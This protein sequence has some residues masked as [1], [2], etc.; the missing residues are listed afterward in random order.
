VA[1]PPRPTDPVTP[2]AAGTAT[3]TGTGTGTATADPG[4]G[5]GGATRF[6][7]GNRPPLTGIRAFVIISILIYHSNFETLPG[8]WASITVFFVLSGF[9]ITSMLV[10]EHDRT[11]R[12]SLRTF[13]ARR[14]VR[15]LPPL[16]ITVVLLAIYAA[17]VAVPDAPQRI[18]GDV[19]AAVF[20]YAD[21]R[22]ASGREPFFGYLGQAWSLSIEEQFYVVWSLLVVAALVLGRRWAAYLVATVGAALSAA[23]GFWLLLR[24]P[25]ASHA[26]VLRVYYGFGSRADALFVGCLLGL[27]ASSGHL[28]RLPASLRRLSPVTA[29]ASAA[30]LGWIAATVTFG[31]RQS[32]LVW[33][34]LTIVASVF[35]ITYFVACPQGLGSRFVGLAP[36][37]LIGNLAYTVY[38][39]H[40]PVYVA[41][42]VD[43]VHWGFWPVELL[44]LA[45]T[46]GVALTSWYLVERPL[47]RWR[48]R[49][50]AEKSR[51]RV[52]RGVPT[53]GPP[54]TVAAGRVDRTD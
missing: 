32:L 37:V 47:M 16:G 20:Y 30:L 36:F 43:T 39:V 51:S 24:H 31:T 15:L 28:D 38:L 3:G 19:S 8:A 25:T 14:A 27:L 2:A 45:I 29:L 22:S 54:A 50:L 41:L 18:W 1:A 23:F 26:T 35:L 12:I 33:L 5:P 46:F 48:R 10:G 49:A 40:W 52:P 42:S 7:L 34:P 11:G 44:R 21:F 53:T 6:R 4:A 13:Y 9:L 17:L